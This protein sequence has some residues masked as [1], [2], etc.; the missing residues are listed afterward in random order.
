MGF[1]S[2]FKGLKALHVSR[3]RVKH[4]V[5]HLMLLEFFSVSKGDDGRADM[6]SQMEALLY[7]LFVKVFYCLQNK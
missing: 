4:S 7:L 5:D 2:G 6:T 1:N 3:I